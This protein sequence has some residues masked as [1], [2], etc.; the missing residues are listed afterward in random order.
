MWKK[1]GTSQCNTMVVIY[2]DFQNITYNVFEEHQ[3]ELALFDTLPIS[4]FVSRQTN[5]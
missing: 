1:P 2:L 3:E 4:R 5:L